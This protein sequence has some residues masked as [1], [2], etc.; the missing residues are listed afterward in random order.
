MGSYCLGCHTYGVLLKSAKRARARGILD[1]CKGMASRRRGGEVWGGEGLGLDSG[2]WVA[3]KARGIL[4]L[5]CCLG[6]SSRVVE[7]VL[8]QGWFSGAGDLPCLDCP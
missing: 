2:I 4:D 1:A 5:F 7:G 8:S 6:V 3:F